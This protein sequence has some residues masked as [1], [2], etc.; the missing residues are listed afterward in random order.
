MWA[1]AQWPLF[2]GTEGLLV[3]HFPDVRVSCV[4]FFLAI[5]LPGF[6]VALQRL[7]AAFPTFYCMFV[8]SSELFHFLGVA[9]K[10]SQ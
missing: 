8:F 1:K 3:P 2:C 5:P 10:G 6:P 4:L 9:K 7:D